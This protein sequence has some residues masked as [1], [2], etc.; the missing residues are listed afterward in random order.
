MGKATTQPRARSSQDDDLVIHAETAHDLAELVGFV[1]LGCV[2]GLCSLLGLVWGRCHIGHTES[3]PWL[4]PPD[5]FARPP[6]LTSPKK[7]LAR[8]LTASTVEDLESGDTWLDIAGVELKDCVLDLTSYETIEVTESRL[9]GVRMITGPNTLV[10]V[11]DS[12]LE[13][14]DLSRMRS[15]SVLRSIIRRCKLAGAELVGAVIDV[16][17]ADCSIRMA[18]LAGVQLQRVGFVDCELADVDLFDANLV[19]VAFDGCR[20]SELSLDRAACER[21]DF[22]EASQ[23]DFKVAQDLTGCLLTVAQTHELATW[24]A[25]QLGASIETEPV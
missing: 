5:P 12:V 10:T 14:C 2:S 7:L 18:N 13:G 19:D 1:E 22:R 25:H 16:E 24:L 6:R 21:V 8:S 15:E 9:V 4:V 17:I 20:I 11:R 3:V 23:L